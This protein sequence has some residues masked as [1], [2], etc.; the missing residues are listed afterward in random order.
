MRVWRGESER[1]REMDRR[2]REER[3]GGTCVRQLL[4][5]CVC[6][7]C[8]HLARLPPNT[9]TFSRALSLAFARQVTL[10]VSRLLRDWEFTFERS[11]PLPVKYDLTLNLDGLMRCTVARRAPDAEAR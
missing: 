1:A 9:P 2:E 4:L 10:G 11:G 6:V 8:G 5:V 7:F 3:E